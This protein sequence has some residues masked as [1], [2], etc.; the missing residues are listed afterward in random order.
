VRRG[1]KAKQGGQIMRIIA[2]TLIALGFVGAMAL[3][4][5]NAAKAQGFYFQ[6]PGVEFGVGRPWYRERYYR[7]YGGPYAYERPYYDWRWRYRHRH[8]NDWGS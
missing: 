5:P 4:V 8:W 7:Y 1:V 6:G 2:G 3:S